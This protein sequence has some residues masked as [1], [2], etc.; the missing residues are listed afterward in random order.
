METSM[1]RTAL[2]A[3]LSAGLLAPGGGWAED[4]EPP[5]RGVIRG[6]PASKGMV[7][8][9]SLELESLKQTAA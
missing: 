9:P 4:Q 1:D 8:S 7:E 5:H 6:D 2:A 3:A